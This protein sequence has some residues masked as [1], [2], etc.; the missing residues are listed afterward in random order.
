VLD[1]SSQS[2]DQ[3]GELRYAHLLDAK[4]ARV[5]NKALSRVAYFFFDNFDARQTTRGRTAL[6]V[7]PEDQRVM[8]HAELAAD[9]SPRHASR[10]SLYRERDH[11]LLNLS[12]YSPTLLAR[13]RDMLAKCLRV[14][15]CLHE[16]APCNVTRAIS[17]RGSARRYSC[18]NTLEFKLSSAIG[19]PLP[20]TAAVGLG[21]I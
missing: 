21:A 17:V 14:H 10:L 5:N 3:I 1:R 13:V 2:R 16:H 19:V 6:P 4:H 11:C 7:T 9:R 18:A 8:A 15:A 12:A 20:L